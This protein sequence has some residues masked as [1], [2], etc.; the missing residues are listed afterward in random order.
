MIQN[1]LV[2]ATQAMP[3]GGVIRI[4]GR[5]VG[6]RGLVAVSPHQAE[7]VRVSIADDGIGIPRDH[8]RR[9]FDPFFS[10][11][12][13][14]RGLGLAT[15]HSIMKKHGG[16]IDVESSLGN[17][18]IFYLYFPVS[19]GKLRTAELD[20][21]L[22]AGA[23]GTI[24]VM[25]DEESVRTLLGRMLTALGYEVILARDGSEAVALFEARRTHEEPCDLV[26]LDLTVRGGMGG[27]SALNHLKAA[28]PEVRAVAMSGYSNS[29]ILADYAAHGFVGRLEKPYR[30]QE[31]KALLMAVMP[32]A[33]VPA[34]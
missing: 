12:E 16:W 26:L 13:K 22:P 11:K 27:V 29:P 10:T 30:M 17:G 28:D 9:I 14:G 34:P 19:K 15:S 6:G 4:Q 21:E 23:G 33:R 8:L 2:N 20:V 3:A 31:L 18:T 24:L 1:V 5:M 25:D 32:G 7:W